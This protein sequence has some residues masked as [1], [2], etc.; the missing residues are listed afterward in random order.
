MAMGS[1]G[2]KEYIG[3]LR[4]QY[5]YANKTQKRLMLDAA[6]QMLGLHRKSLIR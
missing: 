1:I 6:V 4:R 3:E 5:R 2:K